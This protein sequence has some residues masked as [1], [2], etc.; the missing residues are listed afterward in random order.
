VIF[1]LVF[2]LVDKYILYKE[3]MTRFINVYYAS[4]HRCP[5][6][7]VYVVPFPSLIGNDSDGSLTHPYS[8]YQD[9]TNK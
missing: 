2:A 3:M 1:L 8:S 5:W 9:E 7:L 4:L 6:S